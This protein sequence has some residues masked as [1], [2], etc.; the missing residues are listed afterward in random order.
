MKKTQEEKWTQATP[1]QLTW[2]RFKKH[3]LAL[4]SSGCLIFLY[5]IVIF[6]EFFAPYNPLE[7]NSKRI[8]APPQK[9]HF[10]DKNEKTWGLYTYDFVV[11]RDKKTLRPMYQ[12]DPDKKLKIS[13]FVRGSDYKIIANWRGSLHLFGVETGS[14]HLMGTDDLGRDM[15][16]RIIYGGRISL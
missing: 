15:L 16:S 2:L 5:V 11:K 8:F 6:A 7:R 14:L 4:W 9:V 10:Y 1:F 12:Q 3:K 13:F